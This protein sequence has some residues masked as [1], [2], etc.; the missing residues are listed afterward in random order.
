MLIFS[1]VVSCM[2]MVVVWH[3]QSTNPVRAAEG[4]GKRR[5]AG[6]V[7]FPQNGTSSF[8]RSQPWAHLPLLMR[9]TSLITACARSAVLH[10]A[11][12]DAGDSRS[13]ASGPN[14]AVGGF[15]VCKGEGVASNI[16][17]HHPLRPAYVYGS[18]VHVLRG[19]RA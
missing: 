1:L 4:I 3:R 18:S 6:S 2:H 7:R 13:G 11:A 9:A 12:H 8:S 10:C 15:A 17:P 19:S 16:Q 5:T 14:A